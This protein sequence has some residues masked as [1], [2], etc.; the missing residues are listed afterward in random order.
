MQFLYIDLVLILF[1]AF[2]FSHIGPFRILHDKPP[3]A[4]LLAWRPILSL[5][6]HV[7]LVALTQFWPFRF[8]RSQPW[9]EA[10]KNYESS[11]IFLLST[12]QYVTEAV[13]FSASLPYRKSILS[14]RVFIIYLLVAVAFNL[15]IGTQWFKPV[16]GFLELNSFP[17]WKFGL[18]IVLLALIHFFL[19]FFF[20]TFVFDKD[21]SALYRLS[22]LKKRKKNY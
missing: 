20:E 3:D 6:F 14:N 19:A 22:S 9:F 16:N 1:M 21:F 5:L 4:K 12:Y 17:D 8:V 18:L 7:T 15:V 10:R 13:I 11:A 2:F